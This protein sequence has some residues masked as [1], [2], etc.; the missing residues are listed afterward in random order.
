MSQGGFCGQQVAKA[1]PDGGFRPGNGYFLA[2]ETDSMWK[3]AWNQESAGTLGLEQ[4]GV[5]EG[6]WNKTSSETPSNPTLP[7]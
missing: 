5:V 3:P 1:L 4:R 6:G 2:P 7:P